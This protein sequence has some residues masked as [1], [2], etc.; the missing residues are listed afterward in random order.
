MGNSSNTCLEQL[1]AQL[2]ALKPGKAKA[3]AKVNVT[4]VVRQDTLRRSVTSK[5]EAPISWARVLVRLVVE[6]TAGAKDL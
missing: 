2:Q 5:E 4:I 3:R 6:K 1:Q